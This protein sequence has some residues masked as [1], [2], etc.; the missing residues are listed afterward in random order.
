MSSLSSEDTSP[1]EKKVP[2]MD[3]S[4]LHKSL[5]SNSKTEPNSINININTSYETDTLANLENTE[6][7]E[8][9]KNIDVNSEAVIGLVVK[10]SKS[11]KKKCVS[12]G[13]KLKLI[14]LSGLGKCRCEKIFCT[15]HRY[16]ESHDCTFDYKKH[17]EKE[18]REKNQR[19]VADK[20]T[21]I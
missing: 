6:N 18:L 17:A 19:I 21:R 7:I 16:P 5:L 14:E 3:K 11:N 9:I 13:K 12:C 15:Q 20:I 2:K 10:K 1:N 4:K 8:S